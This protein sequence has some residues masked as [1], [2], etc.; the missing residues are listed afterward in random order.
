MSSKNNNPTTLDLQT[1]SNNTP[2]N[3]INLCPTLVLWFTTTPNY[4]NLRPY[5]TDLTVLPNISN[6]LQPPKVN[7]SQRSCKSWLLN[8][9][10]CCILTTIR[11]TGC[12]SKKNHIWH[13][14]TLRTKIGISSLSPD[15]LID[16]NSLPTSKIMTNT[17]EISF[18]CITMGKIL[19][20]GKFN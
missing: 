15:W 7:L 19:L 4:C 6:L 13:N 5:S 18:M 17:K 2:L 8:A 11:I 20:V 1:I 3:I 9:W 10:S 14:I 16:L 12:R